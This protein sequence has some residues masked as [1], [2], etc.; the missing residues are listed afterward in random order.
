MAKY[1]F[2]G[3]RHWSN[4]SFV[5][6]VLETYIPTGSLIVHGDA[7]GLDTVV[8][9]LAGRMYFS[10]VRYPADWDRYQRAAGPIRNREMIAVKPERVFCFHRNIKE[11]KGTKDMYVE[12]IKRY[13][14]VTLFDDQGNIVEKYDG[15]NDLFA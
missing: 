14:P 11:S 13:I 12:C 4:K 7:P 1:V 3:D 9:E 8:D 10:V 5:K 6:E 2:S 15:E